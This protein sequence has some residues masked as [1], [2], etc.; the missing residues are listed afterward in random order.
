MKGVNNMNNN[1]KELYI[2]KNFEDKINRGE[3]SA[4]DIKNF[5]IEKKVSSLIMS[6]G[7]TTIHQNPVVKSDFYCYGEGSIIDGKGSEYWELELEDF[8]HI[9]RYKYAVLGIKELLKERFLTG[10]FRPEKHEL[11]KDKFEIISYSEKSEILKYTF[12]VQQESKLIIFQY[13]YNSALKN[14]EHNIKQDIIETDIKELHS[15]FKQGI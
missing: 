4:R 11:L 1:V 13:T 6:D 3:L 14:S 12:Y 8:L 9:R 15:L 10:D 7:I 5:M 2:D